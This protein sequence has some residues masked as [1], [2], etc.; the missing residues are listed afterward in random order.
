[1]TAAELASRLIACP[2]VSPDEAGCHEV[3]NEYFAAAGFKTSR[4]DV[5]E[6]SNLWATHGSG[7]PVICVT[8]H[9]DVVPPG[10]LGDWRT[11]PFQPVEQNGKLYGRGAADMKGSLA[12]MAVGAV[13]FVQKNPEHTGTVAFLSTSD[14]EGLGVDGTRA[15]LASLREQKVSIA[16]AL[17]GEPTSKAQFGDT[18]KV[19]RRGSLTGYVTVR[20]VQGHVAYPHLADNPIHRL[21]PFLA[22]LVQIQWDEGNDYF[23]PTTLQVANVSAGAGAVNVIPGEVVLNFNLRLSPLTSAES[24]IRRVETMMQKYELDFVVEWSESAKAFLTQDHDLIATTMRSVEA[25]TGVKPNLDTGGGTSDAR[26]FAAEGIP[27]VEFGPVGTT[28]HAANEEVSLADL[29]GMRDVTVNW[30]KDLLKSP[31]G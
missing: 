19:G 4:I 1:M 10:P 3:L 6:V 26:F 2:S 16:A 24:V 17:V 27:V 20:G 7:D 18:I 31:G 15:A 8:G 13:E 30:L 29:D 5:G 23:P 14:E 12:A 28:M 9:C 21:A 22:E 11:D 25:A